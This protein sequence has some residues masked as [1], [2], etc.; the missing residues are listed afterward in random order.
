MSTPVLSGQE[1]KVDLKTGKPIE[2]EDDDIDDSKLPKNGK[3]LLEEKDDEAKD[4][5]NEKKMSKGT[6]RAPIMAEKKQDFSKVNEDQLNT[7]E[8]YSRQASATIATMQEVLLETIRK[9]R[10]IENKKLDKVAELELKYTDRLR[11]DIKAGMR[12][13]FNMGQRDAKF[14]LKK[15][16]TFAMDEEDIYEQVIKNAP[17]LASTSITDDIVKKV[18]IT[19]NAGITQGLAQGEIIKQIK[20]I[21]E[22]YNY[23]IDG[24]LLETTMRTNFATAYNQSKLAYFAPAV[25]SGEIFAYQ[26]SAIMDDRVSPFCEMMNGKIFRANDISTIEPP[27]HF[28]CR[29]TLIPIT[30]DEVENEQIFGATPEENSQFFNE[31]GKFIESSLPSSN[32]WELRPGGFWVQK[33]KE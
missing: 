5:A 24:A 32:S 13:M 20:M 25:N 11:M 21:F 2:Q 15:E 16:M 30:K 27:S 33:P 22:P 14:E 29:S 4:K 19:L 26:Y 23:S 12:E 8:L 7:I 17:M 6:M 10:W 28:N 3:T 1:P 31:N 18:K 9:G